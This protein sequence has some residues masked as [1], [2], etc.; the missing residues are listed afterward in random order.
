MLAFLF[1]IVA[2]VVGSVPATWL[3]MLF[4]GNLGV[5]QVGFW[6][7]LPAGILLTFFFA[8]AGASS[9]NWR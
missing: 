4:L 7:A 6:G 3:L 8:G 2:A 5:T 1:I 9:R